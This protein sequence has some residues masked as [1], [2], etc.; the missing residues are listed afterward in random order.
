MSWK[1]GHTSASLSRRTKTSRDSGDELHIKWYNA[2]RLGDE[3]TMAGLMNGEGD[4]LARLSPGVFVLLA[5][6]ILIGLCATHRIDFSFSRTG[7]DGAQPQQNP[8]GH[9][10]GGNS[11]AAAR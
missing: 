8:G 7:G 11:A 9:A 2:G 10:R 5:S 6:S 1:A 4:K 3:K